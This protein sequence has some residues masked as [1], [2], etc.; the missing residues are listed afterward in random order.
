MAGVAGPRF[1]VAAALDAL[2]VL[3]VRQGQV[4]HGVYLL[5]VVARMRQTMGA[6]VQPADR[7][8]IEG[9]LA[10]ARAPLGDATFTDAW[11]AGQALPVEQ[12]VV[13]AVA[14]PEDDVATPERAD[15]DGA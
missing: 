12:L 2:G 3:A 15:G 5:G 9:A 11:A 6:P 7:P 1:V 4:R 8:M 14:I 10:A 13:H